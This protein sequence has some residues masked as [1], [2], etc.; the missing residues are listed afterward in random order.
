MMKTN[1][2]IKDLALANNNF[3]GTQDIA[4]MLQVN[5]ALI[6]INLLKNAIGIKHA[7]AYGGILASHPT[8]KSLCGLDPDATEADF[9]GQDLKAD[10]AI[11]IAHSVK[12]NRALIKLKINEYE[13][14]IQEIKT[15]TELDLSYKKLQ[16]TDAIVISALLPLNE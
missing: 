10:D 14:P 4:E 9:S 6:T 5:R 16:S 12:V 13:L 3:R 7:E 8:L 1:E 15:A 11:L 2:T